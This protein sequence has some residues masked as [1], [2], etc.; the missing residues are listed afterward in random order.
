MNTAYFLLYARHFTYSIK[1]KKRG[2]MTLKDKV[3]E[4]AYKYSHRGAYATKEN[5]VVMLHDPL[6]KPNVSLFNYSAEDLGLN[7]SS[8][9]V[10]TREIILT[11]EHKE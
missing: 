6:L 9:D 1:H 11:L 8:I 2:L 7:I 4:F 3:W 5:K 10:N